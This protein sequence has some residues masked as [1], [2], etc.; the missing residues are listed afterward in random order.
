M[1]DNKRVIQFDEF[2]DIE[3]FV[4]TASQCDF[5]IDVYYNRVVVDAKSILGMLAIGVKNKLTICYGGENKKFEKLIAKFA[6]A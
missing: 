4:T 3:E 2:K 6:I 1:Y 5:D